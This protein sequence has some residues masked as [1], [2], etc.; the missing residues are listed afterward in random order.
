MTFFKRQT[1]RIRYLP[2]RASHPGEHKLHLASDFTARRLIMGDRLI[3]DCIKK[4]TSAFS[5]LPL[6]QLRAYLCATVVNICPERTA[7]SGLAVSS[8]LSNEK[9]PI[10]QHQ[11]LRVIFYRRYLFQWFSS[12]FSL[13]FKLPQVPPMWLLTQDNTLN[14][15]NG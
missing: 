15:V 9:Q 10:I 6:F 14:P 11:C 5:R 12:I 2:Q 3:W 8:G 13:F 7:V 1:G 4:Y